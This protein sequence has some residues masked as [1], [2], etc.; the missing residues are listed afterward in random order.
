MAKGSSWRHCAAIKLQNS[1]VKTALK[2]ACGN[3]TGGEPIINRPIAQDAPTIGAIVHGLLRKL[4]V[5]IANLLK[6]HT[7]ETNAARMVCNPS[8]GE[9]PIKV[10]MANASRSEERRVGKE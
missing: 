1:A 6:R 2:L 3:S 5:R 4:P 9:K 7:T 8:N 10:P